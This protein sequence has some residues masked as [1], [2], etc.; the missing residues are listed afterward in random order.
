MTDMEKQIR[1]FGH[2]NQ[3]GHSP[4]DMREQGYAEAAIQEALKRARRRVESD[5]IIDLPTK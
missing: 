3:R 4:Q 2:L 1:E 5:R